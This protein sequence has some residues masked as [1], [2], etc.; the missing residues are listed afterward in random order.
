[1]IVIDAGAWVRA[2]VEDGPAGE[3]CR[4]ALVDDPDWL[5]P[6]HAPIEVLR[7]IRRYEAVGQLTSGQADV[8]ARSVWEAE[9]RYA[10][11]EQWL[12]AAVWEHRRN[13]SPYDAP[14]VALALRD[15]LAL[16]T[17]DER[18]GRAARAVGARVLVPGSGV[19]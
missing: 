5:A 9:V 4:A 3:A 18:L 11:P 17:L 2:L 13:I 19:R 12:L 14:Y 15:D 10:S 7:T 8:H 6:G 1:M 16:V